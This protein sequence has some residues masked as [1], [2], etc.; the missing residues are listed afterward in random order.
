[1]SSLGIINNVKAGRTRAR[2]K[3]VREMIRLT[4]AR[5]IDVEDLPSIAAA[6]NEFCTADTDLV[7]VNGGDGTA[8]AVI[9]EFM[10]QGIKGPQLAILPGG[11]TNLSAYDLN[12][13]GR[14]ATAFRVL[15]TQAALSPKQRTTIERPLLEVRRENEAS[16]YGFFLGA[17]AILAG[18][19]HFREH[20]GSRGLRDEL[21]AGVSLLRGLAGIAGREHAWSKHETRVQMSDREE[22]AGPLNLVFATTLERLLL[23]MR[24]WWD[25]QP[26]PVHLTALAH[27]PKA[28]LRT[29][30][31]ILR[32]RAHSRATPANGYHSA[33]VAKFDLVADGFALD[34]QVFN[35][36]PDE[37]I[38]IASTS[39]VTFIRLAD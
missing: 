35:Q 37:A 10:R 28:F 22:F 3:H 4:G 23:G 14:L 5:S 27:E 2:L 25:T 31:T 36:A 7:A 29:A 18:M 6:V 17:G 13:R 33:N 26:G 38:H 12:G 39:P 15:A 1:M 30:P 24:P 20:V 11:T 32:G 9:T 8:Q 34:G 21:A 16:E 19:Q